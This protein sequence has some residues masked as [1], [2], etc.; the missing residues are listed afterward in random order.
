VR[1]HVVTDVVPFEEGAALLHD[2][3]ARRRH[4]I[5]AVLRC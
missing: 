2:V 3:A 1:R 5:Q 4:V